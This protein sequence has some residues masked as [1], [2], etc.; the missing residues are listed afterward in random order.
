MLVTCLT[1]KDLILN[2]DL[3]I[4][5]N[6]LNPASFF[7]WLSS[8]LATLKPRILCTPYAQQANLTLEQ[9]GRTRYGLQPGLQTLTEDGV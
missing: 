2:A 7:R 9:A 3:F 5:Q 4:N 6:Y 1:S 8:L